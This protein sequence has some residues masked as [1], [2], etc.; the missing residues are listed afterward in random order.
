MA[1]GSLWHER[2]MLA[3]EPQAQRKKVNF[4]K[5][6]LGNRHLVI[7]CHVSIKQTGLIM[8]FLK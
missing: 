2:R 8:L 7:Q 6:Q 4:Y 3:L 1:A 5:C